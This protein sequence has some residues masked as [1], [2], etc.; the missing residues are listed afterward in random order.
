M[1]C[2][3]SWGRRWQHCF[4]AAIRLWCGEI[5]TLKDLMHWPRKPSRGVQKRAADDVAGCIFVTSAE[6]F[7][8]PLS[9][10]L[11]CHQSK[12]KLPTPWDWLRFANCVWG[13]LGLALRCMPLRASR[14]WSCVSRK[15]ALVFRVWAEAGCVQ[16]D[17]LHPTG[18]GNQQIQLCLFWLLILTWYFLTR[19]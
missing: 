10:E 17:C 18:W 13:W 14:R 4:R 2:P 1:C 5:V 6:T 11:N 9:A 15:P 8:K 19:W 16:D 7:W 3:N 12:Q